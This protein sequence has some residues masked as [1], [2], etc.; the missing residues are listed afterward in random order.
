MRAMGWETVIKPQVVKILRKGFFE[1]SRAYTSD[2]ARLLLAL[3]GATQGTGSLGPSGAA[4]GTIN[5]TSGMNG[6]DSYGMGIDEQ[7]SPTN[8]K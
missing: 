1:A 6:N 8:Y 5:G 7:E 3:L 4:N 2:F